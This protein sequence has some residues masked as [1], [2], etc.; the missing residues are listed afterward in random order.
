[1]S[2]PFAPH[3]P[4]RDLEE[5][6][7]NG[8]SA[9]SP[10][11]EKS[12]IFISGG[13]GFFGRCLLETFDYLIR[14]R[15]L[16]VELVVLSRN[17]EAFFS[18]AP[19]FR[20]HPH[21]RFIAGD[22]STFEYPEGQFDFVIHAAT[23]VSDKIN[24][25]QPLQIVDSSIAGTRHMLDFA[26]HARTRRFLFTSSGAVYG[27]HPSDL[28]HI[29]ED[30]PGGPDPC[31][32]G[33]VYGESKR[34]AEQL[35][36]LYSKQYP[37]ECLIGRFYAQVGPYLPLDTQFAVGNFLLNALRGE[38]ILIRGDGTPYRT[39]L[40]VTDLVVWLLTILVKG[41]PMHAYNVGSN[42]PVSIIELAR[43]VAK[44]TPS[45]LPIQILG[46]PKPNILPSRYV[47]SNRRATEELGLRE[48]V[49]LEEGLK[50][51]WQF[52]QQSNITS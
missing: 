34:M 30:F 25:E 5:I 47:P 51:H 18:K 3:L 40:Y 15:G 8:V 45:P 38:P 31:N 37:V 1:M 27:R 4:L 48:T 39:Y 32:P 20:D 10:A 41:R 49:S 42:K 44:L 29:P 9:L 43:M 14:E 12:R 24:A 28:S 17:P 6:C 26:V 46:T 22:I 13:T 11:F 7:A 23:D 2:I 50:R 33:S 16:H 52:L 35:C 19:H 21:I 36:A